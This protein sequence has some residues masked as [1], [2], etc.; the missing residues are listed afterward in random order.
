MD[1]H[2]EHGL[3]QQRRAGWPHRHNFCI[4]ILLLSDSV[5]T[6]EMFRR[7]LPRRRI[8]PPFR[9]YPHI[10]GAGGSVTHLGIGGIVKLA[11]DGVAG[12]EHKNGVRLGHRAGHALL[13]GGQND[14][15]AV[16]LRQ[17]ALPR[18]WYRHHQHYMVA[19][20]RAHRSQ[21]IPCCRRWPTTAALGRSSP[22]FRPAAPMLLANPVL[23]TAGRI[24]T[25]QFRQ[26]WVVVH[27]P[28]R[29]LSSPGAYV[30]LTR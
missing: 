2:E 25:L 21:L 6:P 23:R 27:A 19:L 10:F 14:L 7:F 29:T 9:P 13:P 30:R 11:G 12:H 20:R 4:G 24:H 22:R 17:S 26:P 15:R 1:M 5:P 16:G 8:Y 28:A 3:R 18:S